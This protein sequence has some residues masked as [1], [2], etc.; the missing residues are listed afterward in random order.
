MW[1]CDPAGP[2]GDFLSLRRAELVG[3]SLSLYCFTSWAYLLVGC[4]VLLISFLAFYLYVYETL[5]LKKGSLEILE[6]VTMG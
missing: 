1:H 6:S 2:R 4:C 3:F 5:K